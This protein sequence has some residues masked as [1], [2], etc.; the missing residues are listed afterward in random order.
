[1][2]VF[3]LERIDDYTPAGTVID[4]TRN[5]AERLFAEGKIGDPAVNV[6]V[7]ERKFKNMLAFTSSPTT[8]TEMELTDDPEEE[9]ETTLPPRKAKK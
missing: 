8:E 9:A 2:F 6:K 3:T 5:K 4:V 1:M 7:H